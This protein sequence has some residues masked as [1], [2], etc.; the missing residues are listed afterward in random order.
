M[1]S[2]KRFFY[3]LLLASAP[4][5]ATASPATPEIYG[6]IH[7]EYHNSLYNGHEIGK[8]KFGNSKKQHNDI[9]NQQAFN[10]SGNLTIWGVEAYDFAM[11]A[12]D[13]GIPTP[14]YPGTPADID[15]IMELLRRGVPYKVF[16]DTSV[17]ALS[18]VPAKNA[19]CTGVGTAHSEAFCKI[20]EILEHAS[21]SGIY[22]GTTC[23][24]AKEWYQDVLLRYNQS[25]LSGSS[26]KSTVGAQ[27]Y[28]R[29]RIIMAEAKDGNGNPLFPPLGSG[30]SFYSMDVDGTDGQDYVNK[31]VASANW[32]AFIIELFGS[33]GFQISSEMNKDPFLKNS[34]FD[35]TEM[36]EFI[37]IIVL[38]LAKVDDMGRP[39][40]GGVAL[41]YGDL[42]SAGGGSVQEC[43][44][45]CGKET[46][47][48]AGSPDGYDRYRDFLVRLFKLFNSEEVVFY[49]YN[50]GGAPVATKTYNP[51]NVGSD[52]QF[53]IYLS[54]YLNGAQVGESPD[55]GGPIEHIIGDVQNVNEHIM[56]ETGVDVDYRPDDH[57]EKFPRAYWPLLYTLF[58]YGGQGGPKIELDATGINS[59]LAIGVIEGGYQRA[60][61]QSYG[62]SEY[63]K[64]WID[65]VSYD[66]AM[67]NYFNDNP[68]NTQQGAGKVYLDSL[69]NHFP[70]D[71]VL[72]EGNIT[73]R[74][75][76]TGFGSMLT[77][78]S[79][80]KPKPLA[81]Y[82]SSL[83]SDELGCEDDGDDDYA[84][85]CTESDSGRDTDGDG[86]ADI[87]FSTDNAS[88]L[89]P[90]LPFTNIAASLDSTITARDLAA[91]EFRIDNCLYEVNSTQADADSD[92]W[93]DACDNCVNTSNP[94]QMDM[95]GDSIGAACEDT[96]NNEHDFDATNFTCD[97]GNGNP[98]SCSAW[99]YFGCSGSNGNCDG[100]GFTDAEEEEQ[101]TSPIFS[102]TDGDTVADDIDN[103]S[104]IKNQTGQTN[105][106]DG[107]G[108]GDA[109]DLD[110]D[111]DGLADVV[112]SFFN[113]DS[114]NHMVPPLVS[115]GTQQ[116]AGVGM[117]P[118]YIPAPFTD[119][120]PVMLTWNAAN[121]INSGAHVID[122]TNNNEAIH[123][124]NV[125]NYNSIGNWIES[126]NGN[127]NQK[128]GYNFLYPQNLYIDGKAIK[129]RG[130]EDTRTITGWGSAYGYACVLESDGGSYGVWCGSLNGTLGTHVS[131]TV[132]TIT[133]A[134]D[135]AV[136]VGFACA[137]DNGVVKCWAPDGNGV[138]L[139]SYI[140][141]TPVISNSR[142]ALKVATGDKHVCA[143]L[144]DHAIQC[145]GDSTDTST[146][147]VLSNIPPVSSPIAI[148]S[149]AYHACV[150][151][152]NNLPSGNS[153]TCWGEN[154][155]GQATVPAELADSNVVRLESGG[156][157]NC[158]A[159]A[160][161]EVP[162]TG[163][164]LINDLVC[165][166]TPID[167][168]GDG[169]SDRC[170][171]E[172]GTEP[173]NP[174]STSGS[175]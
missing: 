144:D 96:D 35:V 59:K 58:D 72:A 67:V 170:E 44:Y 100:D 10:H 68:I 15:T 167:S 36:E 136:S 155:S 151:H 98:I 111:G 103:C 17:T 166:P 120:D 142:K 87:E 73:I 32:G 1:F 148:S 7:T 94:F 63:K 116:L 126:N 169:E 138:T 23:D 45:F 102:D 132:P 104:W 22:S 109:C 11:L 50:T 34:G 114:A 12:P 175:C 38:I 90:N 162:G 42:L 154:S 108:L 43:S 157:D 46:V 26:K 24:T 77:Y 83:L 172:N 168:D 163:Y 2:V 14:G 107:D 121:G 55:A 128:D 81:A 25:G 76:R 139:P 156:N 61:A 78:E 47:P 137:A 27:F 20:K 89:T 66:Y 75:G 164:L 123:D 28:N 93:G 95:D 119:D 6:S 4:I 160:Q 159:L 54:T 8:D 53:K 110:S 60:T 106:N 56:P 49:A 91:N 88:P 143:L 135:I 158:A 41:E 129:I 82:R 130:V 97:D 173:D 62:L 152:G 19:T 71:M 150:L 84:D 39:I 65:Q 99:D 21:C 124:I 112:E 18:W 134:T 13:E 79:G 48:G 145:W 117:L 165:W 101:G 33:E 171:I 115:A 86:V 30:P 16:G 161:D 64:S 149:G 70:A 37:D 80:F 140:P 131:Q 125:G 153:V 40:Q 146:N 69:G 5:I 57:S 85:P 127:G 118:T 105:D 92:G 174:A 51:G 141:S 29:L 74:N 133:A 52:I 3:S 147:K 31:I 122:K 9:L 113:T